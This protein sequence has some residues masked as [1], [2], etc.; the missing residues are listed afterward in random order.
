MARSLDWGTVNR[1]QLCKNPR[2][3][4]RYAQMENALHD[5]VQ[6]TRRPVM[7]G[8][9]G[10]AE[11]KNTSRAASCG[12]TRTSH[13]LADCLCFGAALLMMSLSARAKGGDEAAP[14]LFAPPSVVD[15]PGRG[16][17]ATENGHSA[18]MPSL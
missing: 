13:A 16:I 17:Q 6:M 14:S 18:L 4:N 15:A 12:Q 3:F 5:I 9:T 10:L 1:T 2:Y 7:I 11:S 8:G